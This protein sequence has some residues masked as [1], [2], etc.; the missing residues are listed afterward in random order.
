MPATH[1]QC[2]FF[3]I[4]GNMIL[5]ETSVCLFH[6]AQITRN[7]RNLKDGGIELIFATWQE[8]K[9]K[10]ANATCFFSLQVSLSH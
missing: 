2:Q 8:T 6:K 5:T 3:F 9:N 7:L 10:L 4:N 1:L